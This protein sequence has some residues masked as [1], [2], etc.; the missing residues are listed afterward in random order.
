MGRTPAP[1][2]DDRSNETLPP[3][4][5]GPPPSESPTWN[6]VVFVLVNP[7]SPPQSLLRCNS[8]MGTQ[9]SPRLVGRSRAQHAPAFRGPRPPLIGLIEVR[10]HDLPL[11]VGAGGGHCLAA[12]QPH[13]LDVHLDIDSARRPGR[14]LGSAVGE[15]HGHGREPQVGAGQRDAGVEEAVAGRVGAGRIS[16]VAGDR[17][18]HRAGG[19]G[20][21]PH[22]RHG[23]D[24]RRDRAWCPPSL[25]GTGGGGM[26]SHS[27][28]RQACGT[29]PGVMRMAAAFR[30]VSGR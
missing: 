26:E 4:L 1:V 8:P 5:K 10:P 17:D 13:Q 12:P 28:C 20:A 2:S 11:G 14:Q 24:D 30:S 21:G 27:R 16:R 19:Q 29:A 15:A 23:G 22:D 18:P 9:W 3:T 6:E 25:A 7:N